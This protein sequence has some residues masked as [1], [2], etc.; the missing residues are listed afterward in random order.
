MK[1]SKRK[2]SIKNKININN[3]IN[4]IKEKRQQNKKILTVAGEEGPLQ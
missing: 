4:N 2:F 3:I 1:Q